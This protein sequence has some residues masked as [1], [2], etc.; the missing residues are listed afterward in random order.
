MARVIIK[1]RIL[2]ESLALNKI[3]KQLITDINWMGAAY[4]ENGAIAA[5]FS[6]T[7]PIS[8]E[9]NEEDAFRKKAITYRNYLKLR[10]GKY[11][12]KLAVSNESDSLG[13]AEQV[14]D[15]PALPEQGITPSSITVAESATKLADLVRNMQ[16]QLVD[17]NN[18]LLYAG[19]Q[20]EPSVEN[21]AAVNAE[22]PVFFWLYNLPSASD[23]DFTANAKLINANGT[24][25]T[26]DAISLKQL[27]SPAG[28]NRGIVLFNVPCKGAP[29]GKYQLII[30]ISNANN[31]LVAS[32]QTDVELI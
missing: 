31:A 30:D 13:T 6:E 2:A 19:T 27:L 21:R 22:I 25:I 26:L 10:P 4:A 32:L 11:R 23:R 28:A 16:A 14:L 18:P 8:I 9:K 15:I 24:A 5:R 17:E 7:R 29:A 3:G 12:I 1:A 20:I